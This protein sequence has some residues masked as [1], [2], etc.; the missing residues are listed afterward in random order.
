MGAS[1]MTRQPPDKA[2]PDGE[3]SALPR[4]IYFIKSADRMEAR[5]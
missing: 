4:A 3:R 1:R 2:S 5:G